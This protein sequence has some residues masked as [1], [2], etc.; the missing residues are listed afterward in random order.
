MALRLSAPRIEPYTNLRETMRGLRPKSPQERNAAK[1]TALINHAQQLSNQ[2]SKDLKAQEYKT[3]V[4]RLLLMQH[5]LQKAL[6]L[7]Q[8]PVAN[9]MVGVWDQNGAGL[10]TGNW[11]LTAS[12]LAQHGV[13]AIFPNMLWPG[14]AHLTS[15]HLPA[16]KTFKLYGD[17]LRQAVKA[18][19]DQGIEVHVWKVCWKA[20]N[21]PSDFRAQLKREGRLQVNANGQAIPWL[22]P[23]HPK[24]IRHE[25][26]A[27]VET[28]R[29]YDVDGIHLD[30]IR[31]PDRHACYSATTRKAFERW[32]GQSIPNWPKPV[33]HKARLSS[34]FERFR[35]EQI[36]SFV[37]QLREELNAV[38]KVQLSAA[39]FGKYPSCVNS[40]GQDYRVWMQDGL[41]D[42]ITPMNYTD[43]PKEFEA[44]LK[45]QNNLPRAWGKVVPGIGAIA[46]ES[47]L[48]PDQIIA[49]VNTARKNGNRGYVLFKLDSSL[50]H[51]VLPLL[52]TGISKPK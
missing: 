15:Q 28:A 49:Q 34:E 11:P 22:C 48:L 13:T 41:V 51:R 43:D 37:R 3:A 20:S 30:Y 33:L 36:T 1:R 17:Q 26:D 10:Y 12:V 18:C 35:A 40:V 4:S 45:V 47:E 6:A 2:I 23:S 8:R 25:I 50:E 42:F 9:E 24:N 16:S 31:Y 5:Q 38:R 46:N 32:H 29:N 27:L 52:S 14:K 39:V 7:S 19:H 44:W 21:A